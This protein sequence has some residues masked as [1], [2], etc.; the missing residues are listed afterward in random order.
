MCSQKCGHLQTTMKSFKKQKMHNHVQMWSKCTVVQ[1]Y[2]TYTPIP[3]ECC[4][5][6]GW[7]QPTQKSYQ[8][9]R[10]SDEGRHWRNHRN[11]HAN[12]DPEGVEEVA[13]RWNCKQN[14][15]SR[16][17]RR[18]KKNQGHTPRPGS[19]H[20]HLRRIFCLF[21]VDPLVSFIC[22]LQHA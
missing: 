13:Q 20:S 4:Q 19:I 10:H 9:H 21:F 14:T 12:E 7:C 16:H 15:V 8:G 5:K 11:C 18:E 22:N 3:R 17:A 1:K 6:G 2:H